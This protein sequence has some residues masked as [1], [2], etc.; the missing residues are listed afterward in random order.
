MN[1]LLLPIVL[2]FPE[3]IMSFQTFPSQPIISCS[4]ALAST[5]RALVSKNEEVA[6]FPSS[7]P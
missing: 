7:L 2:N 4:S 1:V 6:I 5:F 3:T